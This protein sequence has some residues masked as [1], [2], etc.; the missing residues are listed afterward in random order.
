MPVIYHLARDAEW[1]AAARAGRYA[2]TADDRR[3]GFLHFS[4]AE[5][6]AESASRH[7]RGESGIVLIA[8]DA[9]SLGEALCW[10]PSRRGALFPRLYGEL[11]LASVLW[12]AAL[13][14]GDDGLHRFP[15]LD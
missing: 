15:P 8:A 14:L 12:A 1:R 5:Q 7:R 4:T 9:E 10:E 2:G 13:P 6:V 11:P 3:D